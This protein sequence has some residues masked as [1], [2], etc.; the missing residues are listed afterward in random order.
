M[1]LVDAL[2]ELSRIDLGSLEF[3]TSAPQE[4]CH[5]TKGNAIKNL[6]HVVVTVVTEL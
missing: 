6:I 5:P 2:S 4:R 1:E 3:G